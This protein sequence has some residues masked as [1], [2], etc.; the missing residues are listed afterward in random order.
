MKFAIIAAGEGSR[1]QQEGNLFTR[2]TVF[3]A[4]PLFLF[5]CYRVP[6]HVEPHFPRL[7]DKP[8]HPG[9]VVVLLDVQREWYIFQPLGSV[10][11]L[12]GVPPPQLVQNE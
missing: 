10:E 3:A 1:L 4:P 8:Q 12:E 6:L 5:H 7:L 11:H 2:G 9:D